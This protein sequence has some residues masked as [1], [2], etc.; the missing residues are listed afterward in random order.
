MLQNAEMWWPTISSQA[1]VVW[2]SS[3]AACSHR[4]L[5][6]NMKPSQD[7][8]FF[9]YSLQLLPQKEKEHCSKKVFDIKWLNLFSLYFMFAFCI[10]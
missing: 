1:N 10:I 7:G 4:S 2:V 9:M 5:L 8:K 3:F 6:E